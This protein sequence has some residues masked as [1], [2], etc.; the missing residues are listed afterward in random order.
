MSQKFCN[1]LVVRASLP[2]YLDES[3]ILK[4][5]SYMRYNSAPLKTFAEIMKV[6]IDNGL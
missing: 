1:I 6:M 2:K 3:K 4:Y 5:F